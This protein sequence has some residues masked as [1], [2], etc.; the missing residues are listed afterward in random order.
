VTYVLSVSSTT[1]GKPSINWLSMPSRGFDGSWGHKGISGVKV[2][3]H[4]RASRWSFSGTLPIRV[5]R[6]AGSNC[7]MGFVISIWEI[8][9][10]TYNKRI[11]ETR[12]ISYQLYTVMSIEFGGHR[13]ILMNR[14]KFD[15]NN[16]F[17]SYSYPN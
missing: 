12:H 14:L 2:N 6:P 9:I 3:I 5:G 1:P 13:G 17:R 16:S 10:I 7:L 15:W 11:K 8:R 4:S